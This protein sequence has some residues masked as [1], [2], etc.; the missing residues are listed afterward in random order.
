MVWC[1]NNIIKK[2]KKGWEN[3]VEQIPKEGVPK[4]DWQYS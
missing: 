3:N 4:C 2:E 1:S